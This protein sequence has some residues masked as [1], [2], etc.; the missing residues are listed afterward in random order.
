MNL[1]RENCKPNIL[2]REQILELQSNKTMNDD[3]DETR[4][5]PT[6]EEIN[7]DKEFQTCIAKVFNTHFDRIQSLKQ[8]IKE[9]EL[10]MMKDEEL[11]DMERKFLNQ[12]LKYVQEKNTR[13]KQQIDVTSSSLEKEKATTT[14]STSRNK[15]LTPSSSP[16]ITSS[17]TTSKKKDK[18]QLTSRNEDIV[19]EENVK[20]QQ[21]KPTEDLKRKRS[22]RDLVEIPQFSDHEDEPITPNV[23]EREPKRQKLEKKVSPADA[24]MK[25]SLFHKFNTSNDKRQHTL[26]IKNDKKQERKKLPI[27]AMTQDIPAEETSSRKS[28]TKRDT[29]PTERK[30]IVLTPR[31]SPTDKTTK[32]TT[33]SKQP[34]QRSNRSKHV[35]IDLTTP[36]KNKLQLQHSN[37]TSGSSSSSSS[38]QTEKVSK[39]KQTTSTKTSSKQSRNTTS[40]AST[41]KKHTEITNKNKSHFIDDNEDDDLVEEEDDDYYRYMASEESQNNHKKKTVPNYRE[42]EFAHQEVVRKKSERGKLPGHECEE[43]TK[44]Y[45]ELQ[46][47]EFLSEDQRRRLVNECSRHRSKHER[48]RTPDHF[49]DYGGKETF[50]ETTQVETTQIEETQLTQSRT[51]VSLTF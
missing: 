5:I 13:Y 31:H 2:Q 14:T 45:N 15:P 36:K 33:T 16:T 41:S 24:K 23:V 44:F 20:K 34:E 50:L 51:P 17:T 3:N 49:W 18:Q 47:Q 37:S 10:L 7:Y 12:Q 4:I 21:R 19:M 40:D 9:R 26:V 30:K 39:Q 11:W 6:I 42:T 43:C 48:P 32:S 25:H 28:T 38:R 27:P 1:Q 35:S 8:E 29:P 22:D 46:K